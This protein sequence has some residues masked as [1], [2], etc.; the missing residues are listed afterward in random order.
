MPISVSSWPSKPPVLG[1][2]AR[3]CRADRSR[4]AAPRHCSQRCARSAPAARRPGCSALAGGCG[5]AGRPARAAVR[6]AAWRSRTGAIVTNGCSPPTNTLTRPSGSMRI[7]MLASTRRKLSARGPPSADWCRKSRP[8]P[9]ARPPPSR[10][11]R[12]APR[13]RA[14]GCAV[15]PCASRSSC[16]PP[17]STLIAAAEVLLDRRG[18]P[19]RRHIE[20]DRPAATAAT[21]AR[22]RR[23]AD[24]PDQAA[25]IVVRAHHRMAAIEHEPG[26]ERQ[27]PSGLAKAPSAADR[28]ATRRRD[29]QRGACAVHGRGARHRPAPAWVR[30]CASSAASSSWSAGCADCYPRPSCPIGRPLVRRFSVW[31][32]DRLRLP[33]NRFAWR[34]SGFARNPAGSPPPLPPMPNAD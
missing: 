29:D 7:A 22:R 27:P 23:P 20:H 14:A 5:R 6:R 25:T 8:R 26:I 33:A 12:R 9:W 15:W 17:T 10:R 21:T 30:R 4:R 16:V 31:L 3:A 24:E 11:R 18:E 28:A 19:G 34:L 1:I 13:C 32:F 2:R